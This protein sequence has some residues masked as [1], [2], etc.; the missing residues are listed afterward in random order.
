MGPRL[1]CLLTFASTAASA[2]APMQAHSRLAARSASCRTI[3]MSDGTAGVQL[4]NLGWEDEVSQVLEA[5]PYLEEIMAA[6]EDI[7]SDITALLAEFPPTTT[8]P[9]DDIFG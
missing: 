3:V 2:F 9:P 6:E 8:R 7:M 4:G 5:A 1:F